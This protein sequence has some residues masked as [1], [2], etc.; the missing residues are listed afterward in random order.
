MK[1]FFRILICTIF[2]AGIPYAV[3]AQESD[4]GR[5]METAQLSRT[6]EG[7]AAC[8][9]DHCPDLNRACESS[10]AC[11][12]ARACFFQNR[13]Y[14][15]YQATLKCRELPGFDLW[16]QA[17]SCQFIHCGP[18]FMGIDAGERCLTEKCAEVTQRCFGNPECFALKY[19][20][21]D[22]AGTYEECAAKHPQGKADHDAWT[23]CG[24]NTGCF[25]LI[26]T[27]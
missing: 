23:A 4:V 14:R 13:A 5:P 25:A 26:G 21:I 16:M 12:E 7:L 11:Q 17:W 3:L 20:L 1:V 6:Q 2:L 24:R 15:S 8:A 27:P 22:K 18:K 9:R 19:C 10:P